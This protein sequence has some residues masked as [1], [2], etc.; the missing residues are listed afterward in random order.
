MQSPSPVVR[1]P[2]FAVLYVLGAGALI[3]AAVAIPG[4]VGA[5]EGD[6]ILFSR[7]VAHYDNSANPVHPDPNRDVGFGFQSTDEMM[8]GI[9]ELIEVDPGEAAKS[10]ATGGK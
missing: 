9:F 4:P 2:G 7:D 3:V 8:V 5:A 10:A 6:G 1:L